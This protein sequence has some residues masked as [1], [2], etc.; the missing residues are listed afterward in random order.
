M[1][2]EKENL[3]K[4]CPRCLVA[5][6]YSHFNK[7]RSSK[8]GCQVYCRDCV[9][10]ERVVNR[11]RIALYEKNYRDKNKEER[12]LAGKAYYQ[13][14]KEKILESHRAYRLLNVDDVRKKDLKRNVLRYKNP[15][16]RIGCLVRRSVR[17]CISKGGFRGSFR[18]LP[19]SPRELYAH[20]LSNMPDGMEAEDLNSPRVHID[21]IIPLS[22][23]IRKYSEE[24]LNPESE[25]F[26][27]AWSLSNLQ[28]L[29]AKDNLSKSDKVEYCE[30][31][32][33]CQQ[34]T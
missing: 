30:E 2:V 1:T 9:K 29:W 6:E 25:A 3:I 7:S 21:H 19:Y 26:Q 16:Y 14:N 23:F 12:K 10:R 31:V 28:P 34:L 17:E 18:Y 33:A 13:K 8:D 11:Q 24:M 5:K 4:I 32:I 27:K 22:F 15:I 20:L